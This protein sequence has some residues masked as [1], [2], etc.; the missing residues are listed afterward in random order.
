M[1]AAR[2]LV[3]SQLQLPMRRVR[4]KSRGGFAIR[5]L[6]FSP[7]CRLQR[8]YMAT[9]GFDRVG[10]RDVFVDFM[11]EKPDIAAGRRSE[12]AF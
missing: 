6:R 9:D 5:I 3:I 1:S 10:L 7:T 2:N 11:A 4:D 8:G 12:A